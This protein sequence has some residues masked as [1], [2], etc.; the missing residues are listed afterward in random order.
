[1]THGDLQATF[2]TGERGRILGVLRR[3]AHAP[4]GGV[5][6]VP[7]FA[8][9]MNKSRHLFTE[10]ANQLSA[11]GM[12]TAIVDLFGTGDSE[13]EFVDADWTVW[14]SDLVTAV[15]WCRSQGIAVT[16]LLAVRLGCSLGCEA[17]REQG[18]QLKRTVFWQP[19]LS[20][21]RALD[22]FLRLRVAATMMQK[23]GKESIAGLR[24]RLRNG[25]AVEVAGYHVSGRLAEQLD[26]IDLEKSLSDNLGAVLWIEILR[27]RDATPPSPTIA[28]INQGRENGMHIDLRTV[29]GEPFWSSVE[30]VRN[31]LLVAETVRALGGV[32]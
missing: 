11:L 22:Q 10:V 2:L 30:I 27:S 32:S 21:S 20:G 19:V 29:E 6:I 31:P 26:E 9:E 28:T 16:S 3:P 15:D 12:A 4:R 14:K 25:E 1:L 23:D 8:E 13:G 24:G 5:L 17:V 18:W 7:P